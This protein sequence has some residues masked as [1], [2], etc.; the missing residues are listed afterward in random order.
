MVGRPKGLP[1]SGG[2]KKGSTNKRSQTA[3]EI[4]ERFNVSGIEGLCLIAN[5]EPLQCTIGMDKEAGVPTEGK[6]RPTFDQRLTAYKELAQYEAPKLKAVE[7]SGAISVHEAALDE[8]D[9]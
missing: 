9:G 5:G 6:V 1:K 8:L 4:M 2:R 3:A 7:H